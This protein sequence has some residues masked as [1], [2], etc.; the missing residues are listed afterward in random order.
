VTEPLVVDL[1]VEDSAHER[2]LLALLRRVAREAMRT[3]QPQILSGRGGHAK[4]IDA[5]VQAQEAL[6]AG[7]IRRPIADLFLVGIDGNCTTSHEKTKVIRQQCLPEFQDRLVIACPDPHIEKWFMADP[8]SFAQVVDA[9]PNV[10][11]Q[12]CQRDYYKH[13]LASTVTS[14]GHPALLGGLEFADDLVDAMDLYRAGKTDPA[15]AQFLSD[16]RA[17]LQR[18]G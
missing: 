4:A 14:A 8:T 16:L 11:K 5:M 18:L 1:F 6:R 10:G 9:E 15:L 2:L 13:A 3:V 7:G 12:K 17:A